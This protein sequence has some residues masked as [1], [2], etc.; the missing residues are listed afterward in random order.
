MATNEKLLELHSQRD[1]LKARQCL[2]QETIRRAQSELGHIEKQL[3][4]A[5]LVTDVLDGIAIA[6]NG[7]DDGRWLDMRTLAAG[8]GVTTRTVHLYQRV[9]TEYWA[10]R[11]NADCDGRTR[12]TGGHVLGLG[13][14]WTQEQAKAIAERWLKGDETVL[15]QLAA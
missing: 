4:D 7:E 12:F 14:T 5:L 3:N 6:V 10:A 2:L 9:N 11:V 13:Q 1:A 8:E 15:R